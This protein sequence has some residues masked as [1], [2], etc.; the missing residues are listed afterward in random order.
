MSARQDKATTERHAKILRELVKQPSNK[1]CADCKRNDTR[2]ASWNLGVFLCIRCSGIHRSMGTHISKV[3]S[4]DLDIWTPEQMESIQKWGNKRA[5]V[6]WERHLKAGH[7]PPDHKIESFIRSKYETRRWAMDGPPPPDPSVLDHE[8]AGGVV[9]S[10]RQMQSPTPA[11]SSASSTAAPPGP[12]HL[13]KTHPLLSRSIASNKA[14][15][16]KPTSATQAPI[17]DLFDDDPALAPTAA[18][19]AS[20]TAPTPIV[21]ASAPTQPAPASASNIFDL[22]FRTPSAPPPSN[23]PPASAPVP[24]KA[25]SAKAD[26]MSL[27]STP[28]PSA[29]Q[30]QQPNLAGGFFNATPGGVQATSPYA[31]WQGGITSS[32]AP[33]LQQN[34]TQIPGGNEWGGLQMDQNAWGAPQH[35]QVAQQIQSTQTYAQPQ[36]QQSMN[37]VASNPWTQ[38]STSLVSSSDPWASTSGAGAGMGGGVFGTNQAQPKKEKDE[39]DPFANIWA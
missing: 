33:S 23:S 1:N 22:D 35:A 17:I 4:I 8:S 37:S 38:A 16:S 11:P 34:R 27:F 15:P 31:S 19:A 21:T 36:Q 12:A 13:P 7:I 30:S 5:N 32:V 25:Q 10:P 9:S 20:S 14:A 18:P 2:W 29:I 3:K 26:I 6:Y 28:S 24:N 39:R